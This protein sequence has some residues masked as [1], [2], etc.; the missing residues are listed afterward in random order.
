M[1]P[2]GLK[3]EIYY[4]QTF[5]AGWPLVGLIMKKVTEGY[6]DCRP[7]CEALL[8]EVDCDLTVWYQK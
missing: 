6:F 4:V 1:Q 2:Y 3:E 8:V 5:C 7:Q